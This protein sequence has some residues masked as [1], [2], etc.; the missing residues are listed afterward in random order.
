MWQLRW[1]A[2]DKTG[3]LLQPLGEGRIR[4]AFPRQKIRPPVFASE[5]FACRPKNKVAAAT[6]LPLL[7]TCI[8][9]IE[10]GRNQKYDMQ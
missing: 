9:N 5:V 7:Q 2:E 8:G 1:K 4:R 3:G 10:C 6:I